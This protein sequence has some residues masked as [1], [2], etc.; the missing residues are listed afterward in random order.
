MK[1]GVPTET[2]AY[3]SRVGLVPSGVENLTSVGHSVLVQS[4]A[5]EGSGFTDREYEEAGAAVMGSAKA[6]WEESEL[7]VKVK[8][9]QESEWGLLEPNQVLFTFLHLAASEP[10]TDAL[11]GSGAVC[12]A[13]ETV[14]LESG[15]LPLLTPMSE[16]AGRL[17]IVQGAKYLEGY[18]GGRG[19]L[20]GGV[21][22]VLPAHVL[23]LGGGTVGTH[24][25]RM[26]AGLGA[27]VTVL[28]VSLSRLRHLSEVLPPNVTLLHSNALHLRDQLV[29]ADV[30]IGSVLV[31][32][33]KAP[34][35]V[36]R[37]DLSRM[38]SGAV[39][40]DVAVDQ[41]GCV[42]TTR[43]TTHDDPIYT[44][45]GVIHYAV[46][47][48]PGAVP[49]TSTIALTNATF[50]YVRRL[51]DQGW[52]EACRYSEPLCSGL[53]VAA[54]EIVHVGVAEAFGREPRSVGDLVSEESP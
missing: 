6:V 41:G 30:L 34:S 33:R 43:P 38:S 2:K 11:L 31:P 27:R 17:S 51:A 18:F 24:A 47:N 25:A 4:G 23:V 13:Y 54:G 21:P 45:D 49:R 29:G 5:G 40:V 42:E 10:L 50:P 32:G 16:V 19:L 37:E 12:L 44:V 15:E 3:E 52:K 9:P 28:D 48:M 1:I 35:L 26:A 53:N 7:I 14:Q 8:E 20:L 46:T 39:I 22:G 36:R